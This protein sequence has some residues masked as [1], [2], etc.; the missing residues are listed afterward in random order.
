MDCS[1]TVSIRFDSDDEGIK[2]DLARLADQ[3][4][5]PAPAR[6]TGDCDYLLTMNGERLELHRNDPKVSRKTR[7]YVDFLS[8]PSYYRYVNNRTIKQPLARAVG[9]RQ[10]YRPILL[11]ATAGFGEDSFVLAALG[12]S[13]TMLERSPIIW[14]LLENGIKRCRS[15]P[16]IGA[17][18]SRRVRLSRTEARQFLADCKQPFDTIYLDPMYPHRTKSS[19]N[20][21]NMRVLR[22]LAGDDS[23]SG[24]L[25]DAALTHARKRVTVKR[26][27][28][29]ESLGGVEPSFS[30]AARS[31]RYDIYLIP[32]ARSE[33]DPPF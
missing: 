18:F 27:A 11:D 5:L 25:L 23:D 21:Q 29:A 4:G 7:L 12:C 15:H 14:A 22:E 13:V 30:I 8:G 33:D 6:E 26:P 32:Q 10:G 24:Q 28:R 19:L 9:I 2:T 1:A 16:E 20:R 17:I 3:L 31:S